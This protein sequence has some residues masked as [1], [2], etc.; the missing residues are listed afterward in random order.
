MCAVKELTSREDSASTR[1][2]RAA[3]RSMMDRKGRLTAD[4]MTAAASD[5]DRSARSRLWYSGDPRVTR[6]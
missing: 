2:S 5:D 4:G 6:D 1:A 3:T